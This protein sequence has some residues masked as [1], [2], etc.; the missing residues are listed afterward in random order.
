M[1]DSSKSSFQEGYSLAIAGK[2]ELEFEQCISGIAI[3]AFTYNK[4]Q[5]EKNID[6]NNIK[7]QISILPANTN[8]STELQRKLE[9]VLSEM[10]PQ[11]V[12]KAIQEKDEL[13]SQQH[14]TEYR[15]WYNDSEPSGIL[16]DIKAKEKIV[17]NEKEKYNLLIVRE[18]ALTQIFINGNKSITKLSK[19]G[20]KILALALKHKGNCGTT[21]NI[22][23]HLYDLDE[24]EKFKDLRD[25]IKVVKEQPKLKLAIDKF[26]NQPGN[27]E[28][29]SNR[30]NRLITSLNQSFLNE[31]DTKLKANTMDEYEINP[32]IKFC[33]IEKN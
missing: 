7:E 1:S 20:Y 12:G 27:I 2:T 19:M 3:L 8:F 6:S 31:L 9:N 21:W 11:M 16:L 23:I 33:L 26:K 30:V 5:D 14:P 29:Y 13:I 24:A 15:V 4:F 17:N 32:P 28:Y 10:M 22:A 25:M 18:G